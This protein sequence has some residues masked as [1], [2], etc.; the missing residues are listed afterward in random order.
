MFNINN[1]INELKKEEKHNDTRK[2]QLNDDDTSGQ[3]SRG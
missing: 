3:T 1:Y 2:R